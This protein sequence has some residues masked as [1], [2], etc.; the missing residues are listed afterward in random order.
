MIVNFHANPQIERYRFRTGVHEILPIISAWLKFRDV[1]KI[2][3]G[4]YDLWVNQCSENR[5]LLWA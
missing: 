1:Q 4:E 2:L 5:C 3:L